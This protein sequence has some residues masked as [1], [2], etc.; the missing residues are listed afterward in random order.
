[1]VLHGK[2][3]RDTRRVPSLTY[4]SGFFDGATN[5]HLGGGGCILYIS[6]LHF[7]KP[8]IGCGRS[9]NTRAELLAL[10][11]LLFFVSHA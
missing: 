8:K 9:T 10:W 6:E 2:L 4:A 1:M 3:V 5:R 7:Y 11:A